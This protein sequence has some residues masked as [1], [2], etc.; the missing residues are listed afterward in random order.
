MTTVDQTAPRAKRSIPGFAQLQ[1]V[2]RSLMLP[3][4]SLPAAALLLRLGQPDMLGADGLAKNADWLVPVAAV[5]AAAGDALLGN[6]PI[7]FALG[8]AI[9]YARK[10]D[11][12][13]AL[14]AVIGYFVFTGVTKAMSPHVLGKPRP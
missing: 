12:S 14:A 9:G 10:A 8:V 11:G 1:R 2:G 7:L 3:I 4:A 13:T 5:L 6:L